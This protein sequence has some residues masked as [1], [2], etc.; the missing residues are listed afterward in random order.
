[1]RI[2]IF[3]ILEE[4][5]EMTIKDKSLKN[6]QNTWFSLSSNPTC[7][8]ILPGIDKDFKISGV[9]YNYL[10]ISNKKCYTLKIYA[11]MDN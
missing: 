8:V 7:I 10:I 6:A 3:P 1:M 4:N 9:F 5:L 2:V 11:K